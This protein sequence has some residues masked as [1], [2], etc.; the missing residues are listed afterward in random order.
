MTSNAFKLS[1]ILING[2][3]NVD[4]VMIDSHVA[5]TFLDTVSSPGD[6]PVSGNA[7]G[8]QRWSTSTN[9]LF[10]WNGI[11]WMNITVSNYLPSVPSGVENSYNLALDGTAT[12]ITAVSTDPDGTA[13]TWAYSTTGLTNQAAI[14]QSTN[15]FTITPSTVPANNG[16]FDLTISATSNADTISKTTKMTLAH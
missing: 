8:D 7:V 10:F 1:N 4:P 14:S 5:G 9:K 15:V 6:L 11:A 16:I 2:T 13:V 12:V 3:S